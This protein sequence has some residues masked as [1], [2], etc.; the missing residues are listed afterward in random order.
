[1]VPMKPILLGLVLLIAS[2]CSGSAANQHCQSGANGTQCYNDQYATQG[3]R[4][5][6]EGSRP[7][8]STPG[9][10]MPAR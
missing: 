9:S 2:G 4:Q 5:Q 10:P 3:Q 7:E 6:Q 1:M 8:G